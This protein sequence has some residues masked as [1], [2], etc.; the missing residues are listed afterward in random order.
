[1]STNGSQPHA[2]AAQPPPSLSP[3]MGERRPMYGPQGAPLGLD[4]PQPLVQ[5]PS[6]PPPI[7]P[8]APVQVQPASQ[9]Q[10]LDEVPPVY[11]AMILEG[12]KQK[13]TVA[14]IRANIPA[15]ISD[16]AVFNL[17]QQYGQSVWDGAQWLQPPPPAPS[18]MQQPQG[19]QAASPTQQ[20]PLPQMPMAVAAQPAP[21]Q[22]PSAP[23]ASGRRLLKADYDPI[24]K[25]RAAG[26]DSSTIAMELG[27]SPDSVM[28]ALKKLDEAAGQ[29][30][31]QQ[32]QTLSAPALQA[33]AAAAAHGLDLEVGQVLPGV[34][35]NVPLEREILRA[36]GLD[37]RWVE[38]GKFQSGREH[39]EGWLVIDARQ[40]QG[41]DFW[42][43]GLGWREGNTSVVAPERELVEAAAKH[44]LCWVQIGESLWRVERRQV[45]PSKERPKAADGGYLP[46][47]FTV[48]EFAARQAEADHLRKCQI[49]SQPDPLSGVLVD[50]VPGPYQE[51]APQI[52]PVVSD[53]EAG[54]AVRMAEMGM[55]PLRVSAATPTSPPPVDYANP[56]GSWLYDRLH[57][58]NE[59]LAKYELRAELIVHPRR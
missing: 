19:M 54:E 41:V 23:K 8:S 2:P 38:A 27:I 59:K 29:K 17:A 16:R 58:I 37:L 57:Q 32:T 50:V 47:G 31:A 43:L 20:M 14:I 10:L 44:G 6:I 48:E 56:I 3:P 9:P 42:A 52:V 18:F 33:N 30:P 12:L 21:A 4:A 7:Q 40:S 13:A 36:R 22:A 11:Q 34:S 49:A 5:Y 24:R 26:K 15:P 51:G 39:G 25:L 46:P 53:D 1:M 55:A 35:S 45:A 28:R